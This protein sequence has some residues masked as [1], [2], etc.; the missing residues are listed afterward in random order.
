MQ[1]DDINLRTY[2]DVMADYR[3]RYGQAHRAEM[4]MFGNPRQ[5]L[6]EAIWRACMS[7]IPTKPGTRSK[8]HPH[9]RLIP[10]GVLSNAAASLEEQEN[11]IHAAADFAALHALVAASIPGNKEL[12]IY[13]VAHRIGA[14]V[15]LRPVEVYLHAGTRKGVAGL[16]LNAAGKSL[17][18]ASLPEGLRDVEPAEAEDILCIYRIALTRIRQGFAGSPTEVSACWSVDTQNTRRTLRSRCH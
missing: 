4:R 1:T 7:Q 2:A 8:R 18:M 11:E 9:Q 15:G 10:N 13:D 16:G 5:T 14:Y 17:P 3:R 12:L 6:K